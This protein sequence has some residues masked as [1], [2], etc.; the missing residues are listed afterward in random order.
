M[1]DSFTV[2]CR[3][4]RGTAAL[5][6]LWPLLVP[7]AALL[8]AQP[9]SPTISVD[10]RLVVLHAAVRD[11]RGGFVSGLRQQDFRVFEDGALQPI[12]FFEHED[13]P[14]AVG[15]VVDDSGSMRPKRKDVTAAALAFVR[16][17]NPQDQMFVI[18][19][20][21]RVSFGLPTSQ[22]FSASP[23]ALGAALDGAPATGK[24]ALYDAILAG[25]AHLEKSTLDKQVLVVISDGG[26]NASRHTL[27]QVLAAA[28]RSHALIYTIGLFDED[29]GD[30]NPGVL[31][32]IARSS[33][34]EAFLPDS[35]ARVVPICERI[36]VDIRQQYTL[37]YVPPD[38]KPDDTYHAIR[39]TA[40]GP[41]GGKLLVRAR[42]G[43][44]AA[45]A[46]SR[47]A[48]R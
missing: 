42:Q 39:V 34:G 14:V 16:A 40:T 22:L 4:N 3:L 2:K 17:S 46:D 44:V 18:N 15:L 36:A 32:N 25:L 47:E 29:D 10:V 20:N 5:R 8:P 28:A 9:V 12:R 21:E 35:P 33:G 48:V 1:T 13:V 31:R 11:H 38:A 6:R 7:W 30:R 19:F 43:Y 27:R 41:H 24:T 45:P 26:D 23:A 37:G